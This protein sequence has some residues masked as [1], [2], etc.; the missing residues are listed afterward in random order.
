MRWY[1]VSWSCGVVWGG[2]VCGSGGADHPNRHTPS[3]GVLRK[4]GAVGWGRGRRAD[5]R[6]TS[7][8]CNSHHWEIHGRAGKPSCVAGIVLVPE[9]D[10]GSAEAGRLVFGCVGFV[11]GVLGCSRVGVC[12]VG[13][14][15]D[16]AAWCDVLCRRV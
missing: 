9:D 12:G 11:V 10:T 13:M 5:L 1:C 4:E 16:V 8:R 6:V 3:D 14:M 7:R 2:V 15:N